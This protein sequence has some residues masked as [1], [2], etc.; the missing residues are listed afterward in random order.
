MPNALLLVIADPHQTL[1][2]A[3]R[4]CAQE[5]GLSDRIIFLPVIRPLERFLATVAL[6]D[7]WVATLGDDTV[8][9]RQEFRMQLVEVGMLGGSVVAAPTPGLLAHGLKDGDQVVYIDPAQPQLAAEKLAALASDPQVLK[10]M[11][12]RLREH[13]ER[14]FS[15]RHAVDE[16]LDSVRR[17]GPHDASGAVTARASARRS[18][19]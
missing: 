17:K 3:A 10:R 4:E 12:T 2:A 6:V 13:V 16:V 18:G 8:Q 11:G 9:G 14:R 5:R 7:L 15:V 19:G 1:V